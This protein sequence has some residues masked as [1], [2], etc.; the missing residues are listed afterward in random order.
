MIIYNAHNGESKKHNFK[1]LREVIE[2]IIEVDEERNLKIY[3]IGFTEQYEGKS[4]MNLY[5]Q[6]GELKSQHDTYID[7]NY[8]QFLDNEINPY[9]REKYI[10]INRM[11]SYEDNTEQ[12][13]EEKLYKMG[14][15]K[16]PKKYKN[17]FGLDEDP[18]KGLKKEWKDDSTLKKLEN[19]IITND[20][21]IEITKVLNYRLK[22][23]ISDNLSLERKYNNLLEY[24]YTLEQKFKYYIDTNKQK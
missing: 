3:N 23:V 22:E 12:E 18:I 6:N 9:I 13:M 8:M 19:D 21:L 2:N 1:T 5:Y 4:N 20:D 11:K 15:I 16:F 14:K 24:T 17:K 7:F 10:D